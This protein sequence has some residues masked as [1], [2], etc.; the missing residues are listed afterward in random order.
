MG[1]DL[2]QSDAFAGRSYRS[3]LRARGG[4]AWSVQPTVTNSNFGLEAQ[5]KINAVYRTTG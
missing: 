3:L 5:S 4:R 2:Q 1:G